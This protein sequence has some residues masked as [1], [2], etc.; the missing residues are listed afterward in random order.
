MLH[1]LKRLLT[2]ESLPP[3]IHLHVDNDGNE[4]WCDESVCRPAQRPAA[5]FFPPRW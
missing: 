4:M 2:H 3:H 5:P 1:L